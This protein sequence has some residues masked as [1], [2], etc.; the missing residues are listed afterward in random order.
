MEEHEGADAPISEAPDGAED[1]Q[2]QD[3]D[4]SVPKWKLEDVI[5]SRAKEREKRKA[6]EAELAQFREAKKKADE[7]KMMEERRFEE[8][9]KEREEELESMRK[10]IQDRERRELE[11]SLFNAVSDFAGASRQTTEYI[12]TGMIARGELDMPE[13]ID[14]RTVDAVARKLKDAAPDLFKPRNVGGTPPRPGLAVPQTAPAADD[15][16]AWKAIAFQA[17]RKLS[18]STK[19]D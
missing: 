7:A 3:G 13:S 15:I 9:L 17:G 18:G 5:K 6:M 11:N 10:Q 1:T 19:K 2:N 16:E 14:K 12:L 8:L 4:E